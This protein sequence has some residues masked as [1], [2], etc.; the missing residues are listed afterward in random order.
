MPMERGMLPVYAT[1]SV[2]IGIPQPT[3]YLSCSMAGISYI[4]YSPI[5]ILKNK[6]QNFRQ[7]ACMNCTRDPMPAGP[8]F[9]MIRSRV[10]KSWLLNMVVTERKPVVV[11]RLTPC[12]LFRDTWHPMDYFFTPE[13]NFQKSIK[14]EPLLLFM[15]PGTALLSRRRGFT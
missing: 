10:K 11:M 13:I 6:T 7:N 1:W 4:L 3:V 8:I 14:T 15:V 12:M 9:T 5:C 2:W